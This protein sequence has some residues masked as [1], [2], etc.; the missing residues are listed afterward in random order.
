MNVALNNRKN[1]DH[2][3]KFMSGS[4]HFK[5][6]LWEYSDLSAEEIKEEMTGFI[7]HPKAKSVYE[8]EYP[9]NVPAH[10]NYTEKG[11][12][13]RVMNQGLCGGCW[14]FSA[15]GAWEGQIAKKTG[16]LIKLSEQNLIGKTQK[17]LVTEINLCFVFL[18]NRL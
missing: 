9:A 10:V 8:Y 1:E 18:K 6:G 12:V 4:S 13:S 2:N 15:L 7:T 14:A 3:L 17:P 5:M 11:W 16:Q